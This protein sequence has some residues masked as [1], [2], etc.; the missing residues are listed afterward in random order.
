MVFIVVHDPMECVHPEDDKDYQPRGP[1]R[2][3][4][5]PRRVCGGEA[6][7][8]WKWVSESLSG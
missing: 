1:Q 4:L 3:E 5:S 6:R 2:Q 8:L 7:L